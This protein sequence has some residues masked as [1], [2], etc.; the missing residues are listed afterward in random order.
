MTER[1]TPIPYR[2]NSGKGSMFGAGLQ[3]TVRKCKTNLSSDVSEDLCF[4][5][6]CKRP[7]W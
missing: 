4:D 2:F 1:P 3:T 5:T 6:D 7:T